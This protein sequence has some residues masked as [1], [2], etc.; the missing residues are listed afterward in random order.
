MN[1]IQFIPLK[2]L[3]APYVE[4]LHQ[5]YA[6]LALRAWWEV[7]I[8]RREQADKRG[9]WGEK[10]WDGESSCPSIP[11][12]GSLGMGGTPLMEIN[13]FFI[14][15]LLRLCWWGCCSWT[16]FFYFI[17]LTFQNSILNLKIDTY[18]NVVVQPAIFLIVWMY[19]FKGKSAWIGSI[20]GVRGKDLNHRCPSFSHP[21][22]SSP[23][24]KK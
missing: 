12:P 6:R 17:L 21:F 18:S 22:L 19:L 13:A 5:F 10:S 24:K 9:P 2:Y 8:E 14:W 20:K 1:V 3:F 7:M 11:S 16:S 23:I 15:L 4:I